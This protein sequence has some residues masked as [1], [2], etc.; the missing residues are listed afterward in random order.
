MRGGEKVLE[1]LCELFPDADLFTLLHIPGAV[2][3]TIEKRRIKTSFIQSLPL[4]KKRYRY[5]LPLFPLAVEGFDLKGY[6][7]VI[8]SSHCAAKGVIPGPDALHISYIHSPMRYV[9]DMY[10]EYF[11][12]A[13]GLSGLLIRLSAH[14]LRLWDSSSTS[15][16]DF[17]VA[18]SNH[19][20]KRIMRYYRRDSS[21]IYPPV[22]VSRFS[23]AG[24]AP[25]DYYLIVSAFAPYKRLDI[26]VE[27]FN[28]LGKR[29]IIA[30][31]G[32]EEKRLKAMAGKNIEFLGWKGDTEVAELYRNCRAL[33]FPGTEDFGITPVEAMACGRP[34]IAHGK[35]GA[36]ETVRGLNAPEGAGNNPT[37]IFFYEQTARALKDAVEAFEAHMRAFDPRLIRQSA[38]AFDKAVFKEN[39]GKFILDR[40]AEAGVRRYA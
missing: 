6:D 32:Q 30:G 4:A 36:L 39:I 22:D 10:G 25:G 17:F 8:S 19:V 18:N 24:R 5:Y 28:M 34:V 11:G 1:A 37:G 16:V 14:Y 21:V 15:R 7:L 35:G 29:L 12:K 3:G 40:R 20:A 33:V 9:W 38:M 13:R 23:I 31:T 2:S 26:A 27:A